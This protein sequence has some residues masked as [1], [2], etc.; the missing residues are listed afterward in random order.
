MWTLGSLQ[1]ILDKFV[2]KEQRVIFYM[3]IWV[4]VDWILEHAGL[5]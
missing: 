5:I 1:I 4:I 2:I 3:E